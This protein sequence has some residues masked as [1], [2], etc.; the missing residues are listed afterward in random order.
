M[1]TPMKQALADRADRTDEL[2]ASGRQVDMVFKPGQ[3]ALSLRAQ[4]LW[5]LLVKEAGVK[6]ADNTTHTM[7][8]A[9]L[10]QT[11]LGHMTLAERVDTL[12]EL[13]TT[14]VEV[15]APS[16]KVKGRMRVISGPLLDY[17]AR[18]EDDR[19]DLEWSFS[20]VLRTVFANSE[21]W[22]VLSRRAVMA[23]ESRYALRLYELIALR[24]G[25]DHKTAETFTLEDLRSRLGVPVGKLARWQDVKAQ[26]LEP[27]IAEV[28]Q[29]AGFRVTYDPVK[30]GRSV[31][32]VRLSWEVKSAP[33]RKATKRELD[34]PKV[35][36]KARRDG[37]AEQIAAPVIEFPAGT[38][39]H[40]P[41][42]A[43]ALANLPA[44]AR[45]LDLVAEDFR[46]WARRNSKPVRG[47]QV[48]AMFAGFCRS[49]KPAN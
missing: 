10:Y 43:L 36:R 18:D 3:K 31:A 24:A 33:D 48:T 20:R 5:H 38:I 40:T 8:L 16:A 23:F 29:L 26:A 44:P 19:G 34:G 6:L 37:S 35:G 1:S 12:R 13:Q 41:F 7:V 11:G 4:K 15:T 2:V 21:H 9:D 45:D 46:G 25:L 30:R 17:V 47:E 32:S 14:L 42:A 39:R 49:Q 27:A 28:N 22:A